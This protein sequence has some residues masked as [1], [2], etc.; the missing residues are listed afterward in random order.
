M[1]DIIDMEE[2]KNEYVVTD[3][4]VDV[5]KYLNAGDM[6]EQINSLSVIERYI[7]VAL[8]LDN[9]EIKNPVVRDN[10]YPLKDIGQSI[11]YAME[12]VD[13]DDPVIKELV[14][15]TGDKYIDLSILVDSQGN[16][17]PEPANQSEIRDWRL[18]LLD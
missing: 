12:D 4:F 18:K 15:I 9:H 8:S 3:D 6:S 10:L 14:E 17:M 11:Y 13:T 16:D 2:K 1:K 7:L 5:Y